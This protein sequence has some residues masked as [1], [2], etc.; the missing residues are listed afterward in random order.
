MTIDSLVAD[1]VIDPERLGLVWMDVQ[2][3]EAHALAGAATLAEAGVPVVLEYW[4]HG[5]RE[6]GA[7]ERLHELLA[8]R[9]TRFRD[10]RAG[11]GW[12]GTDALAG[13]ADR[14]SGEDGFTDLL[15]V[16]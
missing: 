8:E 11:T 9:Y 5:L 4:P 3:H 13:I 7:L 16:R 6:A 10:L 14:Y 1:G 12:A 2:G 15:V